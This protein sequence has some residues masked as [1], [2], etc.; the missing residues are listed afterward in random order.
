VASI[1]GGI[2]AGLIAGIAMG[3]VSDLAYRLKIFKS[4]L[5]LVDGMFLFRFARS[6]P[7]QGQLYIAGIPIHLVTSAVFG[8]MY[9]LGTV[10]LG[11][12][13]FSPVLTAAYFFLL[14]LSMLFIALPVAGQGL[15]GRK[16]HSATWLE[17]VVLHIV[18]GVA[19]YR[20]L[21]MLAG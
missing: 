20:A 15:A 11:L 16:V 3:I 2:I 9:V 21:Q 12:N 18:F 14:L 7:S 1:I 13:A 17:Q 10:L 8:G 5:F 19:Y 6:K 4:S